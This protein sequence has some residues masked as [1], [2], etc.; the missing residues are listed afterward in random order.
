M[1]HLPSQPTLPSHLASHRSQAQLQPDQLSTHPPC[2]FHTP[3]SHLSIR[4][5]P[6]PSL[7]TVLRYPTTCSLTVSLYI[8]STTTFAFDRRLRDRWRIP[9]IAEKRP[10]NRPYQHNRNRLS[11]AHTANIPRHTA[12]RIPRPRGDTRL[13]S[14]ASKWR[15]CRD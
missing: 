8:P 13:P 2:I 15:Q 3:L 12:E 5:P 1:P 11:G 4:Y 10:R 14:C 7:L 6:P 9:T